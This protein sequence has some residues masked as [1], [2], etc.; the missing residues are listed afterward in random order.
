MKLALFGTQNPP[1]DLLSSTLLNEDT[2]YPAFIKDLKRCKSE[3]IVESPYITTRR[4]SELLPTLEKLKTRKVR[5]VINTRDP[6][7]I[8]DE[9]RREDTQEAVSRLQHLGIH[10]MFT[11]NHHRKLSVMDRSVLYE[12]SLNILSQSNSAEVMRRIESIQLAW[13][14]V[15]FTGI[16]GVTL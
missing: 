15:K 13:Q 4:L 10:V 12:G 3:V 8:A 16:D 7:S 5:V 1:T 14:M 9:H 11:L 2:F 6:R